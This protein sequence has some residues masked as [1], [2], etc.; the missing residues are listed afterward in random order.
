MNPRHHPQTHS[1]HT[2]TLTRCRG[3]RRTAPETM[4]DTGDRHDVWFSNPDNGTTLE[5][6]TDVNSVI[7]AQVGCRLP[8]AL[9]NPPTGPTP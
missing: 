8:R 3:R 7:A 9:L 6:A 2:A 4:Q 5:V 1:R